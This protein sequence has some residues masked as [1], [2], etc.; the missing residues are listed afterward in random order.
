MR[1]LV[2]NA[3][4]SSLKLSVVDGDRVTTATTV[5]RWDGTRDLEPLRAFLDEAVEID[6]VGH[7]VVHGGPRYRTSVQL[8]D[9]VVDYLDSIADLAPLH[10]PRAVA[11]IRSL[12]DLLPDAPVVA[13]A[14]AAADEAPDAT[15]VAARPGVSGRPFAFLKVRWSTSTA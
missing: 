5:D 15:G 6:A 14:C 7:R 3:G 1:V 8:D 10:N 11:A 4:S 2:V 9:E 12:R 13:P